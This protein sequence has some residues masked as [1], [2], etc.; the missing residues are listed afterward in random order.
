MRRDAAPSA[1]SHVPRHWPQFARRISAATFAALSASRALIGRK[2]PYSNGST[3]GIVRGPDNAQI[4][5]YG[6]PVRALH[7]AERFAETASAQLPGRCRRYA[8]PPGAPHLRRTKPQR[9]LFDRHVVFRRLRREGTVA[10]LT[11]NKFPKRKL[12]YLFFRFGIFC[13]TQFRFGT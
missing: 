2:S 12:E 10:A 13:L 9:S 7:H 8:E 3:K 1:A 11:V 4:T 5:R 6:E